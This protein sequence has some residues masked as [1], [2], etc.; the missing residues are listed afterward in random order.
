MKLIHC[1]LTDYQDLFIKAT[2]DGNTYN[3]T[4]IN[5]I[6]YGCLPSSEKTFLI[7]NSTGSTC[8]EID[9][10]GYTVFYGSYSSSPSASSWSIKQNGLDNKFWIG[11]DCNACV[12]GNVTTQ[13][14]ITYGGSDSMYIQ[15]VTGSYLLKL[16]TEGNLQIAGDLCSI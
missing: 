11:D 1:G 6:Y 13:Q 2:Y 3:S 12:Y 16:S 10:L 8:F 7:K 5:S 4:E 9:A 15:N 14:S